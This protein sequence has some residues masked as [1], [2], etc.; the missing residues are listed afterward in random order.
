M[1]S[2][3]NELSDGEKNAKVNV[4]YIYFS[5]DLQVSLIYLWLTAG[6]A[7]NCHIQLFPTCSFN[8]YLKQFFMGSQLEF[9]VDRETILF[10]TWLL[11]LKM[12]KPLLPAY[13][14]GVH[15]EGDQQPFEE[16]PQ[17][18]Q[19]LKVS[20]YFVQVQTIAIETWGLV[21][22]LLGDKVYEMQPRTIKYNSYC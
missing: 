18:R 11:Q 15:K 3:E 17:K 14:F 2:I 20:S 21:L 10:C 8:C 6:L 16:L 12:V 1:R 9:I 19:N 13:F 7:F 5:R 22:L 4:S